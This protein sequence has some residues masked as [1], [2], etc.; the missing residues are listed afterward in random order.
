MKGWSEREMAQFSIFLLRAKS[1]HD[2]EA[3][4]RAATCSACGGTGKHADE[5][6]RSQ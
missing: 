1:A 3:K 2:E 5:K 4:V 6:P